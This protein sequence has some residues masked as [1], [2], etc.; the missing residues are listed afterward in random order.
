[1]PFDCSN[2]RLIKIENE[3]SHDK[4]IGT[5]NMANSLAI[6][7]KLVLNDLDFL[8]KEFESISDN[9]LIKSDKGYIKLSDIKKHLK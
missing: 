9:E 5:T 2:R 7:L 3:R 6:R 8:V 4:N 1:M